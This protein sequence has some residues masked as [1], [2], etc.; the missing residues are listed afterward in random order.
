IDGNI[1]I[2]ITPALDATTWEVENKVRT[3][4]FADQMTFSED[5]FRHQHMLIL[6]E[7]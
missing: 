2:Y 6:R 5:T 4:T 7:S 1:T 3:F